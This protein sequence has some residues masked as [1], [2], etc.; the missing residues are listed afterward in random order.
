MS[1]AGRPGDM[2][3]VAGG[4]G[5]LES[6]FRHDQYSGRLTSRAKARSARI[7]VHIYICMYFFFF[8][9]D[10]YVC[11]FLVFYAFALFHFFS[12][13]FSFCKQPALT[14]RP[15]F[16]NATQ[17][18][19]ACTRMSSRDLGRRRAC[20]GTRRFDQVQQRMARYM[21]LDGEMLEQR[22]GRWSAEAAG[23]RWLKEE[24]GG[25]RRKGA[26]N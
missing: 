2:G 16:F 7:C 5:G 25:S 9:Y 14:H 21:R 26:T 20:R 18:L 17:L 1:F 23:K 12:F 3:R 15:L 8:F 6:R 19:R 4:G 13:S 24:G 11:F 10:C 22:S